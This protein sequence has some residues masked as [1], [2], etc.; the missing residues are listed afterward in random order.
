MLDTPM[1]GVTIT[2][3]DHGG[4]WV[5]LGPSRESQFE[6]GD[7]YSNLAEDLGDDVLGVIA[8]DLLR[9]IEDDDRSRSEWLQM[10]EKALGLLG[11]KIAP[12]RSDS[13]SGGAPFEG[14][15]SYQDGALLEACVRF[16]A[17]AIG[18]LLPAAGPVK[19]HN[20]GAPIQQNDMLAD[21][22]E[23][24]V[25]NFLTVGSPEYVPDHDRM[26]FQVGW[27][28]A[29]I[30]KGY[31][32]P[33]RRR[34]VIESIDAKDLIV[35]DQA[36]DLDSAQRVT[37]VIK[38]NK[39]TLIRM[40][41][42]GAYREIDLSPPERNPTV[43]DTKIEQLQGIS[44]TAS[45]PEEIDRT[46]YECYCDY[47]IP[48]HE[49]KH[50]GKETGLPL[51]YKITIDKASRKILE[52]RRNW[53]EDDE[54]CRKRTT[55][56]MYEYARAFGLWPLG[57]M[58]L[59]GNTV[60]GITAAFRIAIDNGMIGNFPYWI[61][62]KTGSGQDKND[63]RAGPGQGIPFVC[64]ANSKISDKIMPAP[65]V[66]LDPAFMQVVTQLK[67]DVSRI[68]GTAEM[69]VGEGNQQAPVGTTIALIEQ[70]TKVEGAAH[71]RMHQAQGKEFR[72]LR[73]LLQEDP[74]ALWRHTGKPPYN[75]DTIITALNDYDLIPQA[76]PNVSSHMM[77]MSKAEAAKQ[78]V[79]AGPQLWDI[80]SVTEWYC[81]QIGIPE[82]KRFM[83]QNPQMQQSP[84][85]APALGADNGAR[86][87]AAIASQKMKSAD[88]A[89]DRQLKAVE[90]AQKAHDAAQD[91]ALQVQ[92]HQTDLA[93]ELVIHPLS[94][95]IVNNLN[96]VNPEI[97][98]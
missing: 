67:T 21:A 34:P 76:D 61:Y 89:Q 91:R 11:I 52:I 62:A 60:N 41:I 12:P 35:S 23:K 49:H 87:L 75:A 3:D 58:H 81:D 53:K 90:M 96:P 24:A 27:S 22:L 26:F 83:L 38:M 20:E 57:L 77:R 85:G 31:H 63:F 59:M 70:A 79:M 16:Q 33:L 65:R 37:H 42:A 30:V 48:G 25:N 18:E 10:R 94:Q 98:Q 54:D 9:D 32:C 95:A 47:E 82:M 2:D 78:L 92:E 5:D 4:S 36:T 64:D 93:K 46:I 50:K 13:S 8:S 15:S 7:H 29:G 28:G 88:A 6:S 44:K 74:E 51:P 45:R 72:M 69:Q 56:V 14:M 19:V 43:V 17:N 97:P 80:K 71:K 86:A 68:G 73:E 84:Q 66:P 39:P 40:Q 1:A 55:F